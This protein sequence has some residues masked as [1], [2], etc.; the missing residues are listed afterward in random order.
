MITRQSIINESS[1][2]H[3]HEQFDR[4]ICVDASLVLHAILLKEFVLQETFVLENVGVVAQL[5]SNGRGV[6]FLQINEKHIGTDC[7]IYESL[8]KLVS[9]GDTLKMVLLL[10]SLYFPNYAENFA[11]VGTLRAFEDMRNVPLLPPGRRLMGFTSSALCYCEAR[12]ISATAILCKDTYNCDFQVLIW[13]SIC[14]FLKHDDLHFPTN[15]AA[16]HTLQQQSDLLY[17]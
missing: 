4:L 12:Q 15:I 3:D 13:P 16:K 10:D 7:S 8:L 5:L 6:A 1:P 2:Q 14:L 17:T 11:R 9:M